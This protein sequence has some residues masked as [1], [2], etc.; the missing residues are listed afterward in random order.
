[1]YKNSEIRNCRFAFKCNAKWDELVH[2]RN[3]E[4]RFCGE[5][6]REVYYCYS[7]D[8]LAESIRLNRCIAITP[9]SDSEPLLGEPIG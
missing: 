5:C 7:D 6:Q 9:Y 1:M 8:D 4:I 2:T 3:D